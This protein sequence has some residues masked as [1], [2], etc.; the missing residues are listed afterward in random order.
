[1]KKL[2]IRLSDELAA[3]LKQHARDHKRS[4]NR[5]VEWLIEQDLIRARENRNV[6]ENVADAPRLTENTPS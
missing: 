1:M 5:H 6:A 2:T 4:M 3:E